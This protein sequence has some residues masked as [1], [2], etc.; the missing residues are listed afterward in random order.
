M[1][2]R[3]T[4]KLTK[5]IVDQLASGRN[6]RVVFD[7]DLPG[8]GVRVY[9][10]GRKTYVVQSR[11]PRGSRRITLGTHGALT[12]QQARARA[13]VAIERIKAGRDPLERAPGTVA[14][15]TVAELAEK[16]L[17]EHVAV[18]CKASTL[19]RYRQVLR[20]QILPTLGELPVASVRRKHV[21]AL[22]H[23]LRETPTSANHARDILRAMF[24]LARGWGLRPGGADPCRGVRMYRLRRRE[25][26]LTPREYR[27][28]GR[29][30]DEAESQGTAWRPAVAAIRLLALS[31]CRGHEV[32]TLKWPDIDRTAGE[33]RLRDS[34]TGPRMVPITAAIAELLDGIEQAP[35][36]PWVFAGRRPGTHVGGLWQH[37][38]G[39]RDRAGLHDVRLH[40]LRHSY[41]S[42]ALELGESLETIGKLLG[43]N[44]VHST[45]RY[46]HLA[47]ESQRRA[48]D[49]VAGSIEAD[50]LAHETI[51]ADNESVWHE[52]VAPERRS[53]RRG[54]FGAQGTERIDG[55]A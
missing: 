41:A 37:W 27:R 19:R 16:Y 39:L 29:V 26:F 24:S 25:R 47:V 20:N 15:P 3:S 36:N 55:E 12:V 51:I 5:R 13:A 49:K 52:R 54:D 28:L 22:H 38:P 42:R 35:D 43:H 48:V 40:D 23:S 17:T 32:Q 33:I 46:A 50:V 44:R 7:S 21:A 9:P 11:G 18:R 4:V 14:E 30:L 8:F 1:P 2:K 34:K 6:T 45:A 31:G 10:S 53:A